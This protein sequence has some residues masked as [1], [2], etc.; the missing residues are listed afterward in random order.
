MFMEQ[1][2]GHLTSNLP[3]NW[4]VFNLYFCKGHLSLLQQNKDGTALYLCSYLYQTPQFLPTNFTSQFCLVKKKIMLIWS[5]RILPHQVSLPRVKWNSDTH[6]SQH[7]LKEGIFKEDCL[8]SSTPSPLYRKY[9]LCAQKKPKQQKAGH[10]DHQ[11]P[12]QNCSF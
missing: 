5:H 10:L 6:F 4:A 11:H 1:N 12:L 8:R 9:K 7:N 2:L 3:M